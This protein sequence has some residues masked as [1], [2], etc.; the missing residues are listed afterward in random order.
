[1]FRTITVISAVMVAVVLQV[2]TASACNPYQATFQ[3]S[4]AP[5]NPTLG[6]LYYTIQSTCTNNPIHSPQRCGGSFNIPPFTV[7]NQKCELLAQAIIATCGPTGAGFVVTDNCAQSASFIVTDPGCST[8]GTPSDGLLMGISNDNGTLQP[9]SSSA[10]VDYEFDTI[11]PGCDQQ[12]AGDAC[13]IKHSASGQSISGAPQGGVTAS[14]RPPG[15]FAITERVTTTGDETPTAILTALA[16][17]I[18]GQNGGA[19]CALANNRGLWCL[20]PNGATVPMAMQIDDPALS[21][22]C[23]S[24]PPNVVK[25]LVSSIDTAGA[26]SV[27]AS[28]FVVATPVPAAPAWAIALLACLLVGVGVAR[29][30]RRRRGGGAV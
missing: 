21:R 3:T 1:M 9:T 17:L 6:T 22:F 4:V 13:I 29:D 2:R 7:V 12:G 26:P 27:S 8:Q 23:V 16:N 20:T 25:N 19:Q 28:N 5:E 10:T 15:G 18:N 11:T 30:V 14:V 24:G